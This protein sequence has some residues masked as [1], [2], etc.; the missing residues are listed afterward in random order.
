MIESTLT[1]NALDKNSQIGGFAGFCV[2]NISGGVI[3]GSVVNNSTNATYTGGLVGGLNTTSDPTIAGVSMNVSIISAVA[4]S[5]LIY[6]GQSEGDATNKTITMGTAD[7]PIKVVRG[8]TFLGS[9]ISES[10]TLIGTTKS[11][12]EAKP[13]LVSNIE[14]VDALP[15]ENGASNSSFQQG[16]NWNGTWN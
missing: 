15:T 12:T 4:N 1:A 2:K 11:T 16:S 14:F 6:G 8:S 5:G 3:S 9:S 10:T 13:T 7:K